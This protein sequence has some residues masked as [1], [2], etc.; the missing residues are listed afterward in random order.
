MLEYHIYY[1]NVSIKMIT[2]VI[3]IIIIKMIVIW[4]YI[5]LKVYILKYL[6]YLAKMIHVEAIFRLEHVET[7]IN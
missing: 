2:M 4:G 1:I 5:S 3:I 6:P 7:D